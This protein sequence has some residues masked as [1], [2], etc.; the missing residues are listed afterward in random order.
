MISQCG[1]LEHGWVFCSYHLVNLV[2]FIQRLGMFQTFLYYFFPNSLE[3]EDWRCLYGYG[4]G[5]WVSLS[6]IG[7]TGDH[8]SHLVY[9]F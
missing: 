1:L 4:S 6:L 8:I 9:G 7:H 2:G 5:V 3:G